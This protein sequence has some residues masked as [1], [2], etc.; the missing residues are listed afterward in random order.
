MGGGLGSAWRYSRTR[1]KEDDAAFATAERI[2]SGLSSEP[3]IDNRDAE[4]FKGLFRSFSE[5]GHERLVVGA[6][7][8]RGGTIS[9]VLSA[10]ITL[11]I[12]VAAFV[13]KFFGP[14]FVVDHPTHIE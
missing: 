11:P 7:P 14:F 3:G 10:V 13:R 6:P 5:L 9:V 4:C 12:V 1:K 8:L 2:V